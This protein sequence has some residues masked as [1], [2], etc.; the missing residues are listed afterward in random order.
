M[1]LLGNVKRHLFVKVWAGIKG[2][3]QKF[4]SFQLFQ[5]FTLLFHKMILFFHIYFSSFILLFHLRLMILLLQTTHFYL[6][7]IFQ[8]A[9]Y[10]NFA[11]HLLKCSALNFDCIQ[12]QTLSLSDQLQQIMLFKACFQVFSIIF[13][14]ANF[15]FF[16]KNLFIYQN[17]LFH[18]FSTMLE[19]N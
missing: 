7:L 4:I 19:M 5:V 12:N 9:L 10:F 3:S 1:T 8:V 15:Q 18:F 16:K 17:Y 11:Y 13:I 2:F 14:Y 6:I